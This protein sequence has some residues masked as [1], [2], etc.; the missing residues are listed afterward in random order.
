MS[1][2]PIRPWTNV[3]LSNARSPTARMASSRGI[4]ADPQSILV[5]PSIVLAEIRY[6]SAARRIAPEWDTV[7]SAIQNDP[8]FLVFQLDMDIVDT[9]PIKLEIHDA[10]IVSTALTYTEVLHE[11]VAIITKDE[12]IVRSGLTATVW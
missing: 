3:R 9:M 5:V 7:R 10:I 12:T 4:L 1:S 11:E 2:V 8:R 6:L